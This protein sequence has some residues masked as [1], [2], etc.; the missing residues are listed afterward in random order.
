MALDR[1]FELFTGTLNQP[2]RNR[3]TLPPQVNTSLSTDADLE[4]YLA[5]WKE[6]YTNGERI[7]TLTDWSGNARHFTQGTG[8]NKPQFDTGVLNSQPGYFFNGAAYYASISAFMSGDADVMA[9]LKLPGSQSGSG[10]WKFDGGTNNSHCLFAGAIYT[11][12]GGESRFSFSSSASIHTDGWI[13]HIQAKAGSSNWIAYEN[14]NTVKSTQTNVQSWSGGASPV[15]LIGASSD[16]ANGS[17]PSAY[18]HGW[19]MELRMWNR[20]LNSTERNEV[21]TAWNSRYGISVTNF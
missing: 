13:H 19:L 2:N 4:L 12:M 3:R 10:F 21:L 11:A 17:S 9:V 8:A 15:H 16:Q 1:R 14:G 6:S 18:F 20:V 7:D 5:A